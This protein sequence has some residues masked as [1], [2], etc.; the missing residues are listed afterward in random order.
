[1]LQRCHD[2]KI[3]L[4]VYGGY[5]IGKSAIP[6]QVF[7]EEAKRQNRE[8]VVWDKTTK[9]QKEAMIANPE[10]Y[11]LFCDQ[12][13]GQMDVTDLRG[14][15]NMMNADMLQTI[16]YAW[17]IYFS[18]PKASGALFFDELN[19]AVPTVAGSA[20]QII[21]DR[22]VSDRKLS[23]DVFI[24][25]AGNR[26]EDR[27]HTFDMPAPL[28]DRFAEV[29]VHH[30]VDE[31]AE[32][33]SGVVNPHL[34]AFIQWKPN[35]LYNVNS[36]KND[37]DST[38]RG[39]E[40]ASTLIGDLDIT[41]NDAFELVSISLGE[42][43][44]TQFQAYSKYY[45]QLKWDSIYKK[46]EQVKGFEVDKLWAVAGGMTDQ[47]LKGVKDPRFEE[48]MD[49]TLEMRPDF[50]LV[51]LKMMKDGNKKTFTTQI[52]KCK[53]FTKIVKEHAKFIID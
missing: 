45:S 4:F 7:E 52:K 21:H 40:R 28:R 32:W 38:P 30:N 23:D 13:V 53:K 1:M 8:F 22:S 35:L 16:P 41:S 12:R 50:A 33:A 49:V 24:F 20:Y 47:F 26:A 15:P 51:A 27:A 42:A 6:K 17:V 25:G 34:I 19:L 10:K 29:E 48:M 2:A 5:G 46:P 14:I 31:W 43:F 36:K 9:E 37:K 11:F 39:I 18:Q 3:P 44:A